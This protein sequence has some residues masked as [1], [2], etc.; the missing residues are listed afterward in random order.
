METSIVDLKEGQSGTIVS[1]TGGSAF[2]RKLRAMGIREGQIIKL[3]SRQPF[4]GPLVVEVN[5][6]Q[7]TLGRGMAE[8]IIVRN[9]S[10]SL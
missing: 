6:R 7:T 9:G 4:G 3:V 10:D 8:R 2:Q 5:R 1:L